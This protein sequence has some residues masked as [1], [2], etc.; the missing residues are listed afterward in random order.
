MYQEVVKTNAFY[1]REAS[2]IHPS[3][4]LDIASHYYEDNRKK[5]VE[6]KHGQEIIDIGK[7]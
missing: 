2:E 6:T 5:I 7:H 3:W 1:M 4:I